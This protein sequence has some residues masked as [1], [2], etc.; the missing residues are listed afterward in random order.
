MDHPFSTKIKTESSSGSQT[1][2][3][4]SNNEI[5]YQKNGRNN[6]SKEQTDLVLNSIDIIRLII[7]LSLQMI[8]IMSKKKNR[9][10]YSLAYN[11][12]V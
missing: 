3:M 6:L 5:N 10:L 8:S 7:S 12:M 4:A 1:R 9:Q 2:A 11:S